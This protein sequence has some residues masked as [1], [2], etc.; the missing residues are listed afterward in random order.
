MMETSSEKVEGLGLDGRELPAK[1]RT[2]TARTEIIQ[3]RTEHVQQGERRLPLKEWVAK[4]RYS[5]T[6]VETVTVEASGERRR[7]LSVIR[8]VL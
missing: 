8:A 2:K 6:L 1:A 7:V 5:R 3:T 4:R